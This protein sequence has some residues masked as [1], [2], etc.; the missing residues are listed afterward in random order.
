LETLGY[1]LG[2]HQDGEHGVLGVKVEE[3]D[4]GSNSYGRLAANGRF[5]WLE[6]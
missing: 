2:L 3:I 5:P 1:G 4:P 6:R